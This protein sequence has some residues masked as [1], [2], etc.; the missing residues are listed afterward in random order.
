[1]TGNER[2]LITP[3][4]QPDMSSEASLTNTKNGQSTI[5]HDQY[6]STDIAGVVEELMDHDENIGEK[7]TLSGMNVNKQ[8]LK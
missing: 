7:I 6:D 1:M 8:Y 2:T 4:D 5:R 3:P